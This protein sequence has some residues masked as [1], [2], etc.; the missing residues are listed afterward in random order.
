M[1]RLKGQEKSN[2]SLKS[3]ILFI[4]AGQWSKSSAKYLAATASQVAV[5][6]PATEQLKIRNYILITVPLICI[7]PNKRT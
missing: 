5:T 4:L 7:R 6:H 1:I 2:S 3:V